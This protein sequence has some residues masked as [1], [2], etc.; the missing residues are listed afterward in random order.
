MNFLGRTK[1]NLTCGDF[2]E[3]V[4][5]IVAEECPAPLLIG[6]DII[7]RMN[8]NGYDTTIDIAR[9]T[10]TIGKKFTK[11]CMHYDEKRKMY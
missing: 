7:G 5:L 2:S 1:V 3:D 8:R 9:K 10:V 4:D 6:T 11:F